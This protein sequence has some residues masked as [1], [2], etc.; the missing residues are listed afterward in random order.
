MDLD[1]AH[2]A[3]LAGLEVLHNTT[4]ADCKKRKA[5]SRALWKLGSWAGWVAWV[6]GASSL[7]AGSRLSGKW[8]L[9]E[10]ARV[11]GTHTYE[12]TLLWW[13]HPRSTLRTGNRR[14]AHSS[15]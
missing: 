3:V 15:L 1:V 13:W 14:C 8:G 11:L 7:E 6:V 4:L 2:G 5:N 10:T 12:D 9:E